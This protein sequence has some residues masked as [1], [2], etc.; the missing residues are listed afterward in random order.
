MVKIWK[1]Y[2]IRTNSGKLYT[3][4]TVDLEKRFKQH[5]T[6]KGAKFFRMDSPKEIVYFETLDNRSKA[7]KRENKIKKMTRKEKLNLISLKK[8]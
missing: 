3:G 5:L 6:S 1:V 4:I 7:L 8:I 2:I